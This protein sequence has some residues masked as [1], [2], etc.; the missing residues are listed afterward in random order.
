[1][2]KKKEPKPKS[3]K[4]TEIFNIKREWIANNLTDKLNWP[5]DM[6]ILGQM[7]EIVNNLDFWKTFKLWQKFD[8]L[9]WFLNASGKAYLLQQY[10]K[11][12]K[13]EIMEKLVV[14]NPENTYNLGN[15]VGEDVKQVA[16]KPK[17]LADF[18]K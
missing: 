8:H 4:Q 16:A 14:K 10:D 6:K 7:M 17:T 5:R 15:K 2:R 12:K 13:G 9:Y 11:W 3:P 18:L 1:M